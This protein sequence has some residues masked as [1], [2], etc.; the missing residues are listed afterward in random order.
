M[1]RQML[2]VGGR[3]I[4]TGKRREGLGDRKST[5]RK[6]PRRAEKLEGGYE[7][8]IIVAISAKFRGRFEIIALGRGSFL[9]G[10]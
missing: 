8:F 5:G 6:W 1:L 3:P 4:R 9:L 7:P 2:G 10:S